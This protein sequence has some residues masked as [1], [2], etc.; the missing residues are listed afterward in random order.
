MKKVQKNNRRRKAYG[1]GSYILG[2][3]SLS[4]TAHD[5]SSAATTVFGVFAVLYTTDAP[6][7]RLHLVQSIWQLSGIVFPPRLHGTM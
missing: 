3:I 7:V 4:L 5:D 6:F 2:V 1:T